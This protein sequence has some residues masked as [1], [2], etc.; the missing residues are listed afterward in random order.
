MAFTALP[1]FTGKSVVQVSAAEEKEILQQ[2]TGFSVNGFSSDRVGRIWLLLQVAAENKT[3]YLQTINQ[4][5]LSAEMNELVALYSALPVFAYP[6]DWESRCAEGIRTNIAGVLEATVYENPYPSE[7]LSEAE[8]NQM[9]LKAIFTGK[10]I[11]RII[12]LEERAN[13]AL[14]HMLIDYAH[15]RQAA[16]RPVDPQLWRLADPFASEKK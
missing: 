15:E 11:N 10:E 1:R 7:Y 5:F 13:M 4:H 9:V 3:F 14:S 16:G 12:G 8:W 6:Q 2:R